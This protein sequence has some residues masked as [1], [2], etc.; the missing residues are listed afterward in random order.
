MVNLDCDNA[1]K[2]AQGT[3]ADV[4]YFSING[5]ADIYAKNIDLSTGFGIFDVYEKGEKYLFKWHRID[6]LE[7]LDFRPEFLVKEIKNINKLTKIKQII[8][9]ERT[10]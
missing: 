6:K 7:E 2:A 3:S 5:E 4:K 10:R 1:V 9:D 8:A